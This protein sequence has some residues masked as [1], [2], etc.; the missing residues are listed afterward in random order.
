MYEV[1]V[2][3]YRYQGLDQSQTIHL[4]LCGYLLFVKTQK[5]FNEL[6]VEMITSI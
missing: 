5:C 3:L 1:E 2:A 4:V 6:S